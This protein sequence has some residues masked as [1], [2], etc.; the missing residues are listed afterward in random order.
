MIADV[1][2]IMWKEWKEVLLQ[3]GGMRRG[4]LNLI[5]LVGIFGVFLPLQTGLAWLTSPVVLGSW[6]WVPIMLVVNVIADSF[7]GERERH[8]LE[9]LLATRLPDSAILLGKMLAAIGYAWG[10]TL[11][12]LVLGAIT[13]NVAHWQG[14]L[15]MYPPHV[16]AGGVGISL[17][18]AG[19]AAGAG[20]LV[21]LRASTVRQA[22]QTLGMAT[23][24]LVWL[25]ILAINLLPKSWQA[26]IAQGLSTT[27]S[28]RALAVAMLV[29]VAVD[30]ALVAAAR[31]RFR[32]ARLILD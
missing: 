31:T 12:G 11:A 1:W 23:L 26:T 4:W 29:L 21:S 10:V 5:I 9:T 2:T 22:Q 14:R 3:R 13:V 17:L 7:A 28:T 30:V 6:A 15:V 8:T 16:I 24:C 18:T 25:P 32:R 19:L 27:D 20:V